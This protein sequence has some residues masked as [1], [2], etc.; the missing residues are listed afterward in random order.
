MPRNS[1][2]LTLEPGMLSSTPLPPAFAVVGAR[3]SHILGQAQA[4]ADAGACAAMIW[5]PDDRAYAAFARAFP[6]VERVHDLDVI[7]CADAI[8]FV[9]AAPI[10][11]ERAWLGIQC[12]EAGK[13]YLVD[14]PG[15]L[16]RFELEAV[17]HACERTGRRFIVW[18][19]ERLSSPATLAAL[20]L[21]HAGTIGD[22]VGCTILAPHQLRPSERPDWF[23]APEF[24]GDIIVDLGSHHF[25]LLLEATGNA[26]LEVTSAV[27]DCVHFSEHDGFLDLATVTVVGPNFQAT[28]HLDWLSPDTLGTW[29]AGRIFFRGTRGY[30]EVRREIDLAGRPGSNHLLWVNESGSHREQWDGRTL[31]FASDY[32]ADLASGAH[33]AIDPDRWR[34]ASRLALDASELATTHRARTLR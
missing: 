3:H 19:H 11:A 14:K 10:A 18:F 6:D 23:W 13:D 28:I 5:E 26:P 31:R 27:A 32:L 21:V 1:A 17:Q 20:D 29:G 34:Q 22:L 25:D 30:L 12:L 2:S 16:T 24:A 8:G 33:T 7:L 4:L 9:T 15:V